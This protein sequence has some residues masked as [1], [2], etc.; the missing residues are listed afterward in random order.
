MSYESLPAT[1]EVHIL[2]RSPRHRTIHHQ[3]ALLIEVLDSA[4]ESLEELHLEIDCGELAEQLE[5]DVEDEFVHSL[6][7]F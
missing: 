4:K 3:S 1:K 5:P 7:H 6:V 2:E